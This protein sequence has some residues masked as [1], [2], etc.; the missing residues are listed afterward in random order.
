[1][2]ELLNNKTHILTHSGKLL[3]PFNPN[4]DTIEL[5]DI[6]IS[7]SRQCRFAGHTKTFY[8]VA[9][10][11]VRVCDIVSDKYKLTALLHDASEAFL[12]DIPKP[13]KHRMPE[14]LEAEDNLMKVIAQKFGFI[15]PLP[16]EVKEA[17]NHIL[18]NEFN[19][20]MLS[21]RNMTWAMATS[22]RIFIQRYYQYKRKEK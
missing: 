4:P 8:S 15:Y 17:D 6:A 12:L 19:N 7:L 20:V 22:H 16:E 18:R 3:D 1:M 10:H 5:N 21:S 11:S 13:L 14:Y 2:E 9:E